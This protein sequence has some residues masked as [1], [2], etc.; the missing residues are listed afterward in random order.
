DVDRNLSVVAAAERL[1]QRPNRTRMPTTLVTLTDRDQVHDVQ[2]A[3]NRRSRRSSVPFFG[4]DWH[5]ERDQ[6][7]TDL[8]RDGCVVLYEPRRNLVNAG[9]ENAQHARLGGVP[10]R[11]AGPRRDPHRHILTGNDLA[12]DSAK[13]LLALMNFAEACRKAARRI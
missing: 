12:K 10:S 6:R 5:A 11:C 9:V 1:H 4:L 8:R 7:L 13:F 2:N 3:L